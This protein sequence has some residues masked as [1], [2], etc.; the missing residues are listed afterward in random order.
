MVNVFSRTMEN[1]EK[2]SQK[3]KITEDT[4]YGKSR[5]KDWV[6]LTGIFCQTYMN[7]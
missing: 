4:G 1:A 5:R 3:R 7:L 2:L 6:Y